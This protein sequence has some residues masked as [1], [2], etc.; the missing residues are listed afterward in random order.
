MDERPGRTVALQYGINVTG[1]LGILL[2]AKSKELILAV[3][4]IMDCLINEV[5]FRVSNQLYTV[6]L[7]YAGE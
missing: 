4:P 2:E 7:K 1:V 3:K 6:I 5:N